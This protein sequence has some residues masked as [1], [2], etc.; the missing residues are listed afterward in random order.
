MRLLLELQALHHLSVWR[1]L[2][3]SHVSTGPAQ[4]DAVD[5]PFGAKPPKTTEWMAPI[6]AHASIA[7]AVSKIIGLADAIGKSAH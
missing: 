5:E 1:A 3:A 6:R 2:Q 7:T 4:R